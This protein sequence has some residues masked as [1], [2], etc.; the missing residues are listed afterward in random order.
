[1][2]RRFALLVNPA[3]AG[4]RALRAVGPA[5]GVLA[6]AGASFRVL[7]TRDLDHARESAA[8]ALAAGET[9][10]AV[11]GDGLVGCLAGAL[12][13]GEGRL[14]IVPGGR[15]N[16]LARVL[17][18]PTDPARAARVALDGE[19]RL[20]DVAE[21]NGRPF[22]GIASLGFDSEANRIA[23]EARLVRGRLVY[24]YAALRALA[25][26][27]HARFSVEV[28]GRR[29]ELAGYSVA[30]ANSQA[31]GGGMRLVPHAELDDGR[32]DVL[33]VSEHAKLAWLRDVPKVFSGAHVRSPHA[34][35]SRGRVVK[36]DADRPFTVYADGDPIAELPLTV[37]VT[38][39]ALRVIVPRA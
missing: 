26:W 19:E 2:S 17:G 33:V 13:G 1:M 12:R 30:V 5:A 6:G 9:V 25:G 31:Y 18:I 4:G 28:D 38:P 34:H 7:E 36:V 10:V 20:I 11:G 23:N 16:D 35:W 37:T 24:L 3:A 39:R 29:S 27:R 14:A 22:V 15:G 8:E 32:L 21:A